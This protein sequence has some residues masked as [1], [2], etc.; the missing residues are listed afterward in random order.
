MWASMSKTERVRRAAKHRELCT[1]PANEPWAPW[2]LLKK[3]ETKCIYLAH[4]CILTA[5]PGPSRGQD[6]WM[7]V[8]WMKEEGTIGHREPQS[9]KR[10]WGPLS[11]PE[12]GLITSV[13]AYSVEVADVDN[14]E[15]NLLGQDGCC[16]I[17][18]HLSASQGRKPW[19]VD[20][21]PSHSQSQR[22]NK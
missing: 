11:Q 12:E 13:P 2:F 10:D 1:H 15:T 4:R 17:K 18:P 14:Q 5:G 3:V 19:G 22:Q 20:H 6:L 21:W 9:P 8:Q 16:R 7:M